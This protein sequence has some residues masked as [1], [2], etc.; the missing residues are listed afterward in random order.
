VDRHL[1]RWEAGISKRTH[2]DAH[3]VIETLFGVEDNSPTDW[4]EPDYELGAL[5]ADT[6]VFGRGSEDFERSREDPETSAFLGLSYILGRTRQ[7]R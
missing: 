5:I 3:G 7:G 1:R 4:T 6:N 2:G